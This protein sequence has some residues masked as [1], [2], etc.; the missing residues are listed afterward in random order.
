MKLIDEKN[1]KA[2]LCQDD[3]YISARDWGCGTI[4]LNNNQQWTL[5]KQDECGGRAWR[6]TIPITTSEV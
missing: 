4:R 5:V 2:V 3:G 6:Y 1:E